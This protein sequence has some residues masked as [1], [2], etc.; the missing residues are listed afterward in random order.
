MIRQQIVLK[1]SGLW[2]Y[3]YDDGKLVKLKRAYPNKDC[4][5]KIDSSFIS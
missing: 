5:V 4:V 3:T 1:Q 2:V